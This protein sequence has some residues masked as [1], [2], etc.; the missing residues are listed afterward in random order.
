M[1]GLPKTFNKNFIRLRLRLCNRLHNQRG[2]RLYNSASEFV[3]VSVPY[4]VRTVQCP[5][6]TVSVPYR[7]RTVFR[8]FYRTVFSAIATVTVAFFSLTVGRAKRTEPLILT[9]LILVFEL[10]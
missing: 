1:T 8:F 6:R 10:K 5:Y 4:R 3:T 9:V 2:N 7:V